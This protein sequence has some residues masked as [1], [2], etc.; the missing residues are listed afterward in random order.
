MWVVVVVGAYLLPLPELIA[1]VLEK[2]SRTLILN[3]I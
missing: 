3:R 1:F 2:G